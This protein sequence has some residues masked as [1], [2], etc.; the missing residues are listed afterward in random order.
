MAADIMTALSV[1][2]VAAEA[3]AAFSP[4]RVCG[5]NDKSG[6]G[7]SRERKSKIFHEL[8]F[9]KTPH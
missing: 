5:I 1:A 3:V 9:H 6:D 2:V 4:A 7:E 8:G